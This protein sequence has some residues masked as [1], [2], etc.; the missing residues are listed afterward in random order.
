MNRNDTGP[1]PRALH[2][3]PLS[4]TQAQA[5]TP[6]QAPAQ[7]LIVTAQLPHGLFSRLEGLRRAHYPPARN[8]VPV[9]V[10]LFHA[11]PPSS[12]GEV[13]GLLARAARGASR[14]ADAG[15]FDMGRGTGIAIASPALADLREELGHALHGLLSAQDQGT[16]RFHVTVQA[17]VD[18]AEARALQAQLRAGWRDEAFAFPALALH[19]LV[20]R[21]GGG[22]G[23]DTLGEWPFRGHR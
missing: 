14:R 11:L 20:P 9:H 6:S 17:K 12:L 22:A 10:T 18:R 3:Q 2:V 16:L 13:R 15:V 21:P 8:H 1:A 4:Q 5:Q 23:W 19:R 7:A